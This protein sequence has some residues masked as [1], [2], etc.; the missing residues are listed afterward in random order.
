MFGEVRSYYVFGGEL[1]L[2]KIAWRK[3]T[4]RRTHPG[5]SPLEWITVRTEPMPALMRQLIRSIRLI[6][7]HPQAVGLLN[8]LPTDDKKSHD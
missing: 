5:K 1:L 8:F 6:A 4:L 3:T 2:F 7:W